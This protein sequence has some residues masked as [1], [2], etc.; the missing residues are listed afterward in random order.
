MT[1]SEG[2]RCDL[3]IKM[4]SSNL[5]DLEYD[6]SGKLDL[7]DIYDKS[8]PVDYFSKL[9][10]LDYRIPQEAKPVFQRVIAARRET[11]GQTSAKLVDIGCSYGVN[12]ALLKYGLT[13]QQLYRLY[14]DA[15]EDRSELLTRDRAVYSEP[16][17]PNLECVGL[18][19][20]ERAVEYALDAG[21]LDAG[22]TAD[23][24]AEPPAGSDAVAIAGADLVISTGCFGYVSERTLE[25]VLEPSVNRQPWM[26]HLVLR[27]FDFAPAEQMLAE[28]GYVTERADRLFPQRRFASAQE[29]A[30]ALETLSERAI[31]PTGAE[32]D[33]WYFAQLHV[34][35]PAA[36]AASPLAQI[37]EGA[38]MAAG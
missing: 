36:A 26:A 15:P 35:R 6:E 9:H 19:A 11:T 8:V 17:D 38:G 22:V 28:H 7:T 13:M 18:D 12:A 2:M 30:H 16:T 29:Q 37:V 10:D 4:E 23:L 1:R 33:G 31:D 24:E 27:I 5:A 14:A 21:T 34:S 25:R 3:S 20:A 32:A